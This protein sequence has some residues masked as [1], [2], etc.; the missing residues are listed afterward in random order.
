MG[1]DSNTLPESESAARRNF[2]GSDGL[3]AS[4]ANTSRANTSQ[5]NSSLGGRSPAINPAEI[6]SLVRQL[7]A[8]Q[9]GSDDALGWLLVECRNYL[10][11][12]AN[13]EVESQLQAKIAPSDL[14]Q[15]TFYDVICKFGQF[16]GTTEAELLS[17]MVRILKTRYLKAVSRFRYTQKRNI[18]RELPP[19][20]GA[21]DNRVPLEFAASDKTPG[22]AAIAGE[23]EQTIRSAMNRLSRDY[24]QV[25][26]LRSWQRL[27]YAEIS[28]QMNRSPEASRK[29]WTRAAEQLG[30][31][32]EHLDDTC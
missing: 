10:L 23:N 8:A 24:R 7:E 4:R 19:I 6:C 11:L 22:A 16:R 2:L 9:A 12:V 17:W 26:E 18:A 25:I 3:S 14:V 21:S 27:S 28:L 13:R 31:E 20:G 5:E 29:L 32:L 1:E 30:L 15:E